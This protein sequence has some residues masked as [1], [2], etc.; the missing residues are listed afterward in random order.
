MSLRELPAG[1][2]VLRPPLVTRLNNSPCLDRKPSHRTNLDVSHLTLVLATQS[3]SGLE[4]A[5]LA[6]S[7]SATIIEASDLPTIDVD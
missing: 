5:G 1:A 2:S 4:P 3:R 7:C 6:P